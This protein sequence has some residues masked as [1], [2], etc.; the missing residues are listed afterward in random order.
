MIHIREARGIGQ[1]VTCKIAV[2]AY[3]PDRHIYFQPGMIGVI[4]DEMPKV[5]IKKGPGLDGRDT[6]FVI[7][8][9]HEGKLYR[10]S[11][12]LCNLVSLKEK[13]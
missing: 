4:V 11:L 7:D 6:F 3:I 1:K 12:N 10:T 9:Q 5:C 8:F 2:P 13:L